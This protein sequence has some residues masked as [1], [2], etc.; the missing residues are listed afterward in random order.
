MIPNFEEMGKHFDKYY[1]DDNFIKCRKKDEIVEI[2]KFATLN[3][4]QFSTFVNNL[5]KSHSKTEI[6]EI[7]Q[8]IKITPEN[9]IHFTYEILELLG[10]IL[11]IPLIISIHDILKQAKQIIPVPIK[12]QQKIE[13]QNSNIQKQA[14]ETKSKETKNENIVKESR[15]DELKTIRKSN[16]DKI[17]DLLVK[18]A[19]E[20]DIDTIKYAVA[21]HYCKSNQKFSGD[22]MILH[23]ARNSNVKLMKYLH[24][25]GADIQ[26]RNEGITVLHLL[27]ISNNVDGV[28]YSIKYIDVNDQENSNGFTPLHCAAANNS[29]DVCSLLFGIDKVDKKRLDSNGRTALDLAEEFH[30]PEIVKI[31]KS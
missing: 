11:E 16:F 1:N 7:M 31:L 6:F 3:Y 26:S 9:L 14:P 15:L 5:A 4:E 27:S 23:A 28:K 18:C 25:F 2:V 13:K 8:H 10:R 30:H 22:S 19:N 12:K 29:I 21:K 20:D 17:Y 24:Q